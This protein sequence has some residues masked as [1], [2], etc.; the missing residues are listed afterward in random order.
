MAKKTIYS[1]EYRSLV[2]RLREHREAQRI[3]QT[4]LAMKLGWPQQR[5]SAVEAGSRR[6]DV[7]EYFQLT[8]ALGLTR[9]RAMLLVPLDTQKR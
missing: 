4:S 2:E 9:R 5:L 8:S 1:A 7:M 3:S 6:L